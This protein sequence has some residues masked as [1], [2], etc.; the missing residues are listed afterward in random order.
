MVTEYLAESVAAEGKVCTSSIEVSS[1]SRH[2]FLSKTLEAMLWAV[3][4]HGLELT[5][6]WVVIPTEEPVRMTVNVTA[7]SKA[8]LVLP[9]HGSIFLVC[10]RRSSTT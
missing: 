6:F 3:D 5:V 2:R 1:L 8:K 10:A 9:T 4:D 7:F